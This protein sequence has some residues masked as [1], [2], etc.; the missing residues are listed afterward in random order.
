MYMLLFAIFI[1]GLRLFKIK[2]LCIFRISQF[3]VGVNKY[4]EAMKH[5][6]SL[7]TRFRMRFEGEESPERM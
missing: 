1:I 4:M 5:G 3:I 2:S 6:F 7:G